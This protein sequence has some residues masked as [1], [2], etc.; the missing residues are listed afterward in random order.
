[1]MREGLASPHIDSRA[2][3]V[4]PLGLSRALAAPGRQAGVSD[5]EFAHTVLVLD[6]EPVDAAPILDLR[7]RKGVRRRGVKLAVATSRPSS[8]DAN[9]RVALR[10]APGAGGA[11]LQAL[12]AALGG[13]GDLVGLAAAAG[14]A[15]DDV[16][17][18]AE[19]LRSVGEDVV[20]VWGERLAADPDALRAL[21][22][23]AD[24]L[25]LTGAD[26]AGLLELPAQTNGRGL[27]EAGCLPNAGPGWSDV[28]DGALGA[29][30]I[31]R[32]AA[33]GE[34]TALYLLHVDPL[35]SHPEPGVWRDAL[36]KAAVVVAHASA[37]TE[38]IREFATVVFPAESY[39]EKEG[40]VTHPDGRVQRLRPAIGRPGDVRMEWQVIADLS[41]RLGVDLGVLGGAVGR[42]SRQLFDAVPFYAG[43]TLETLGGHG[44]RWPETVAA[45]A[46]P[47]GDGGP[48]ALDAPSAAPSPNGALR[49]GT[50]RS[51][52]D[53][54]E[55]EM[56]PS[57][58]FLAA[59]PLAELSPVDAQ[60]LGIASGQRVRLGAD[61]ATV[62]AEAVVRHAVPAGTVFVAE[63]PGNA[64]A[65]GL[66]EVRPA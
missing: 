7:I 9:A 20:I 44:I 17:A 55:V 13:P 49:L 31:A 28:A 25:D 34:L 58:R 48:F 19:L 66:V 4:V 5:L 57:L 60:R 62:D 51:V 8:L 47:A 32:A 42:A 2:G 61:G 63:Q 1:M 37:L 43:L 12:D 23:V 11:F 39:A 40:T 18:T 3:P 30:D 36:E 14:A 59:R 50:F 26:G 45:S 64:L 54:P 16:R 41:A 15:A 53:A 6:C 35:R 27:R 21:I 22:N 65:P 38:A 10:Y 56:S 46:L 29:P 52:W 33:S 24:R